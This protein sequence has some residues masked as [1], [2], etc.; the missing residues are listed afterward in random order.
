M[1]I[2]VFIDHFNKTQIGNEN[3][4]KYLYKCL[5]YPYLSRCCYKM[6]ENGCKKK[7]HTEPKKF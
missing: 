3:E 1:A 5:K 2:A 4:R 6:N 7:W